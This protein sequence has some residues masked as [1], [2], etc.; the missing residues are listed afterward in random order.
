MLPKAFY[1]LLLSQNS[2]PKPALPLNHES[3]LHFDDKTKMSSFSTS[4]HLYPS[5]PPSLLLRKCIF[6]WRLNSP[7]HFSQAL[8]T[9]FSCTVKLFLCLTFP[10]SSKHVCLYYSRRI[11]LVSYFPQDI[12]FFI[13]DYRTVIKSVFIP[14]VSTTSYHIHRHSTPVWATSPSPSHWKA[15][16][17]KLTNDVYVVKKAIFSFLILL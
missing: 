17:S 11:L 14:T 16:Y 5:L 13:F 7:P 2:C 15:I 6:Y 8:H 10:I 12:T 1:I 9:L 4:L 3:A